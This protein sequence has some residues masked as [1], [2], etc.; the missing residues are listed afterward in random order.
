M[1]D[2]VRSFEALVTL[3]HVMVR[4][5]SQPGDDEPH[6]Y[7]LSLPGGVTMYGLSPLSNPLGDDHRLA[8]FVRRGMRWSVGVEARGA[9]V[10]ARVVVSAAQGKLMGADESLTAFMK[11]LGDVDDC[12]TYTATVRLDAVHDIRTVAERLT[13]QACSHDTDAARDLNTLLSKLTV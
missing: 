4:G 9:A 10:V 8:T 6:Y 2:A 11:R 13:Y 3:A 5:A 12:G 1:D 7:R